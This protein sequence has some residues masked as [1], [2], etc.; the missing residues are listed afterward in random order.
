MSAIAILLQVQAVTGSFG[1]AGLAIAA[2]SLGQAAA[3]PLGGRAIGRWGAR[4]VILVCAFGSGVLLVVIAV[5]P[6]LVRPFPLG[7]L[8]ALVAGAGVLTPPVQPA[9]RTIYQR[10]VAS[11]RLGPLLALDAS[12]Q[13]LIFVVAPVVITVV[14]GQFGPA[15][16][17]LTVACVLVAGC[18][19]FALSAEVRHVQIPPTTRRIGSVATSPAVLVGVLVGMA[20]V[21]ASSAVEVAVV[22]AFFDGKLVAGLLLALYSMSSLIGGVLIGAARARAWSLTRRM[23]VVVVGLILCLVLPG[24]WGIGVGLFLAG[25]GVAP[26][27]AVTYLLVSRTVAF[28]DTAEA[29]GWLGTGVLVGAA[30]GAAGAGVAIDAAGVPAAF[31][32]AVLLALAGA[33]TAACAVPALPQEPDPHAPASM[34]P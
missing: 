16:G 23:L 5:G 18:L 8:L 19:W 29:Y 1:L 2:L 24:V 22:A 4:R 6:L 11:D 15:I 20:L 10:L 9:A 34:E 33:V 14:A 25:L 27:L 26:A 32:F 17:V 3:G 30:V 13:E 7:V 12:T 21:G 31:G 28:E